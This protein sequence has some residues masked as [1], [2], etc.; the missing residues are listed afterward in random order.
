MPLARTAS[1]LA[2]EVGQAAKGLIAR[3]DPGLS[4]NAFRLRVAKAL[5]NGYTDELTDAATPFINREAKAQGAFY[6]KTC[7]L[8]VEHKVFDEAYEKAG[9]L[10]QSELVALKKEADDVARRSRSR[11][12]TRRAPVPPRK[13]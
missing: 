13:P 10:A 1:G 8:A 4:F 2:Y 12:G 9:D 11:S 7:D 3:G 5:N 6:S